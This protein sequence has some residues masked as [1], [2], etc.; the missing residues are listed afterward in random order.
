MCA[1]YCRQNGGG[2]GGG[3]AAF[4]RR[5]SNLLHV[6]FEVTGGDNPAYFRPG[7]PG[8]KYAKA[9]IPHP[10]PRFSS[11]FGSIQTSAF[12][13]DQAQETQVSVYAEL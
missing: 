13:W 6:F 12:A 8:L 1:R 10:S 2:S 4:A 3:S 11:R 7:T 9:H 5:L